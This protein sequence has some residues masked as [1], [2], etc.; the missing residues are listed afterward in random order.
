MPEL[1]RVP[2]ALIDEPQMPVR[3]AM[4]EHKMA[5]LV[6]SMR[7]IGLL[8]P[9]VLKPAD[10]RYEIEAGHR[11]F[12]AALTLQWTDI[13]ALVFETHELAAGAAMLAENVI[14]EDITAAEEAVLFDE[15]QDKY[16]LDEAGLVARFRRSPDY[17]GERLRLLRG[18]MNVFAAVIERKISFSVARELNKCT[19]QPHRSYLLDA[20]I[21]S[22]TGA[23]TVASWIAQW[24]AQPVQAVSAANPTEPSGPLEPASD[25]GIACC[26]CGGARDPYNLVSVYIHK[27]ELEEIQKMMKKLAQGEPA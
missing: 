23:R 13:P 17:I 22:G 9:I 21:R 27:W 8:Q 25:P 7:E 5:E 10:G 16:K 14:R 19:D 4:D 2:L 3:V 18:D 6:D 24:R 1:K 20:A 15:A 26:L 12:R 11:R